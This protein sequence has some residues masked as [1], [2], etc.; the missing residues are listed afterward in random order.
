MNSYVQI[1]AC[2]NP[3][4]FFDELIPE[5]GLEVHGWRLFIR[6]IPMPIPDM[7]GRI[8]SV[9]TTWNW[10]Y[11]ESD[12]EEAQLMRFTQDKLP[13]FRQLIRALAG[14]R[15]THLSGGME[16]SMYFEEFVKDG[17]CRNIAPYHVNVG[18]GVLNVR[19]KDADGNVVFD[20]KEA[21]AEQARQALQ[22]A[23]DE[24]RI[25]STSFVKHLG[26]DYFRRA[27]ESF[28]LA[29]GADEHAINHLYDVRDAVTE[30][31]GKEELARQALNLTKAEWS[32]FGKIFNDGAV[33]GGRHNGKHPAPLRPMTKE[34]R[35]QVISFARAMLF[36]YGRY[37]ENQEAAAREQAT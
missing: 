8:A 16:F 15:H 35:T 30:K 9:D 33:E 31:F 6:R 2:P 12:Y 17:V 21:E 3:N 5:S 29:F 36:A 23:K 1:R 37:L 32:N 10:L 7:D 34:Q 27:W 19:V 22:D 28:S 11:A 4:N 25:T 26:D 24:L 14:V 13:T 18:V 20:A